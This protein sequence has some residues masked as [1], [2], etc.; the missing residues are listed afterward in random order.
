MAGAQDKHTINTHTL[1]IG[2]PLFCDRRSTCVE[3][4]NV[5]PPSDAVSW[6]FYT[7]S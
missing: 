5:T 1:I 7:S 6:H 3:Q 4:A 2:R